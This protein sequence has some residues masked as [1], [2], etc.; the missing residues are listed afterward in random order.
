[1]WSPGQIISETVK[2][3][4]GT[5]LCLKLQK[6]KSLS[7]LTHEEASGL[8]VWGHLLATITPLQSVVEI[9]SLQQPLLRDLDS[10]G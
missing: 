8:L 9:R 6:Q 5:P 3:T 4:K 1:V 2:K 10:G 7:H